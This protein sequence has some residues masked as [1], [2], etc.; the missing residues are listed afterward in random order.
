M[1]APAEDEAAD[2]EEDCRAA[3]AAEALRLVGL[4]E[5]AAAGLGAGR[6]LDCDLEGD[7]ECDLAAGLVPSSAFLAG[8]GLLITITGSQWYST[9]ELGTL[10]WRFTGKSPSGLRGL[11]AISHPI[12]ERLET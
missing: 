6:D 7:L 9:I 5:T 11:G 10:R 8:E 1:G 3:A 12:A 4:L 2:G